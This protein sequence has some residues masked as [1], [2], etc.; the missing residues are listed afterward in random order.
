MRKRGI[1]V[2]RYEDTTAGIY[3]RPMTHEDTERIVAW[4]NSEAVRKNFIYQAPFTKEGHENWIRTMIETG[5]VVQMM[6]CDTATY[7]A[8]GSV[9][10]RDIDRQHNKAEYG[11]FIGEPSARGRGVGTAAAKLMLSY[12]F[13]E[14]K[15]HRVYLRAF[16]ENRQAIRSYEKAGFVQEGLFR[17]DVCIDGKYR[18]IVRMAAVRVDETKADG[19]N[20]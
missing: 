7:E 4:R 17:D 3:L 2:K 15:L 1:A 20:L 5:K 6:I 13:G 18:D 14:E 12:C 19:Q 8:L 9:Y 16:A 10:I 11:I